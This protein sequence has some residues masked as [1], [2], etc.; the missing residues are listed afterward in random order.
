MH[1]LYLF[2]FIWLEIPSWYQLHAVE[3]HER[4][5]VFVIDD[6]ELLPFVVNVRTHVE[7]ATISKD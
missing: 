3:I 7:L 2:H 4:F 5:F 1:S 6:A